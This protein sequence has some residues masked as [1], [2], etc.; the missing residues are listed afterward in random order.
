M[1]NMNNMRSDAFFQQFRYWDL[2]LLVV[3]EAL[4][5]EQG[6]VSRAAKRIGLSQS[7]MSHALNRLREMLDDPLFVKQ[8]HRMHPT[9]RALALAPVVANWLGDIRGQLN[10]SMFDPQP[11]SK[12]LISPFMS[13]WSVWCYPL[14]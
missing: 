10:P 14:C 7:A 8:G 12:R 5:C 11:F 13:I 1:Q 4:H 3:F 9:A 2:N 6:N